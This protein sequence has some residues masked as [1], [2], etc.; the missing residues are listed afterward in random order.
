MLRE[1]QIL[2]GQR[3]IPFSVVFKA[4]GLS[5]LPFVT[6]ASA[7]HGRHKTSSAHANTERTVYENLTFDTTL[8]YKK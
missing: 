1:A 8:A 3:V 5:T 2:Q 4:A 7:Y 6:T